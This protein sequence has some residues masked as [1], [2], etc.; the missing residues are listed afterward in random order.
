MTPKHQ[1]LV[2]KLLKLA[3]RRAAELL[4]G[5][6]SQTREARIEDLRVSPLGQ[7]LTNLAMYAE[8]YSVPDDIRG[9][10]LFIGRYFYGDP[11]HSKGFKFPEKFHTMELGT[12]INDAL[13]RFYEE[14]RPG[15]L[16]TMADM[17]ELFRVKRQTVHQWIKAGQIFPVYINNASRFYIKDVDRLQAIREEAS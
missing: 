3:A 13:V 6:G 17:R 8:G 11:L 16:L 10:A 9:A 7:H 5:I 15:Q 1:Q 2:D 14:E 12:L 4:A